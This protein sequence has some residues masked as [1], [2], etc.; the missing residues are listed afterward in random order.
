MIPYQVAL[1]GY[2]PLA[3]IIMAG[4]NNA[5][6]FSL[7]YLIG[8]MF[9]PS[10]LE[11]EIPGVPDL[12]KENVPGLGILI[13]TVLFHPRIFDRFRLS[14]LDFLFVFGM[15]AAFI[16]AYIN[17]F[18]VRYGVSQMLDV[19][20]SFALP[21]VLA[22]IHLGTPASI[23]TFMI[24]LVLLSCIYVPMSLLEFRMSPQIHTWVYGYFQ[25]VFQQHMRGSFW[26]PI[27]FF[28]HA[29]AL[30]RFYALATFL[31]L[32][33]ARPA[34]VRLFGNSGK[35]VFLAP[36]AG[37][38]LE[39]SISPV[40]LF[41]FMSALYLAI[42]WRHWTVL[43]MPVLAFTWFGF[44]FAG[45]EIGYGSVDRFT[46]VSSERAQ[47][48]EYRLQAL[49]EY[50]SVI[51]NRP[52]FG[53]GGFNHG[54]IEGRATDSQSLIFLLQSG[55]IGTLAYLGWWFGAMWAAARTANRM[56][57]TPLGR[58]AAA[59][60][61]FGSIALTYTVVD[62][63]LEHFLMFGLAAMFGIDAWLRSAPGASQLPQ[64]LHAQGRRR[65]SA[66]A[67]GAA[68]P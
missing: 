41:V 29:L 9:L 22:R 16:T 33:P 43:I 53:H 27:V 10:G 48:F 40:L 19:L 28:Y 15:L 67:A 35:Y 59:W 8:L 23:K 1:I 20:M 34:L 3:A 6:A 37:L 30:G 5:L 24:T 21:I 49:R 26:R 39:Q 57:G 62:A 2:I 56:R 65:L 45:I 17:G 52:W 64:R 46:P 42:Q 44:V 7:A 60:A 4:R 31:A 36:L 14:K 68:A 32:F 50:R 11:F 66:D 55:L 54:R 63:A 47:S 18:G 51:L 12:T 58:T 13:G 61:A 38:L 25:H